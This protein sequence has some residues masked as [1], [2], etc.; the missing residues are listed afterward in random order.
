[1]A[2]LTINNSNKPTT[3]RLKLTYTSGSGNITITKIESCRTDGYD[4]NDVGTCT[5]Y[6]KVGN[7]ERSFSKKGVYFTKNSNYS[8][9][10]S[11]NISFNTTGTQSVQITF[12]SANSNINGSKFTTSINAGVKAPTLELG[13]GYDSSHRYTIPNASDGIS[14]H[15]TNTNNL[16][17]YFQYYVGSWKNFTSRDTGD[18]WYGHGVTSAQLTEILTYL[19]NTQYPNLQ[20]RAWN[21]NGA[22]STIYLYLYVAN[23]I[24]PTLGSI[25][26]SAYCNVTG[27]ENMFIKGLSKPI[28]TFNNASGVQGS[29][30]SSYL[31]GS[32]TGDTRSDFVLSMNGNVS[33][34]SNF[35]NLSVSGS[36]TITAYVKDTRS[37][38]SASVSQTFNVIDY[39][40]PS[41]TALVIQRCL[42]DGTL[43]EDGEYARLYVTYKVYPVN[44]GNTDKN[45]RTL[46][47]SLDNSTWTTIPTTQWESSLFVIIGNGEFDTSGTYTI[48]VKLEDRTTSVVQSVNLAPSKKLRSLYHGSD[49]EGI[50]LGRKAN[51]PGFHDYLGATFHNGLNIGT[52]NV[53]TELSNKQA[54]LVSGTN[55]KTINNTSILG[56]GNI[57]T[58]AIVYREFSTTLTIPANS[59]A[60]TSATPPTISGYSVLV[61][62]VRSLSGASSG[63][64]L[65]SIATNG[66]IT[67]VNNTD[68]SRTI[69]I[70]GRFIYIKN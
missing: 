3:M 20:V 7:D 58:T 6:V 30:I 14:F 21:S 16:E 45:T 18:G 68:T 42:Q 43:N 13:D 9:L 39:G 48:Y 22:S 28:V 27:F 38:N 41:L 67:G 12:S 32:L 29:T 65:V 24:V 50:T 23:S 15:L 66:D 47:Y 57:D 4:T 8:T 37:R 60:Y 55:I 25:S 40:T 62:V 26:V 17:T 5:I 33:N 11:Q 54:K 36:N 53:A 64:M 19:N 51:E 56:S 44:D 35:N 1:M 59:S 2:E 63:Y 69:T 70:Y 34:T 46:S 31:I 10:L 52:T 61:G 49:G